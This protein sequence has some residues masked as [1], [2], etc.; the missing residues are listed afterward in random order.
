MRNTRRLRYLIP[1]F[2]V[3]LATPPMA[4]Q[5]AP[6]EGIRQN[7]PKVHAIV[8][9]RI[10]PRPGRVIESGTVIVRD[11]LIVDV[12]E[13]VSPPPDCRLWDGAGL[14]VYPGLIEPYAHIGLETDKDADTP[15]WNPHV[16]SHFAAAT[17]YAPEKKELE[18]LRALG[19]TAA[20]VVPEAGLFRG[21]SA[22]VTLADGP[23]L[24]TV[25]RPGVAQ[26]LALRK[27]SGGPRSPG[28]LTYPT[29]LMGTIALARQTFLDA[30]W[31]RD[32]HAAYGRSPRGQQA[33]ELNDA[34]AELVPVVAGEG[35]LA[36]EVGSDLMFLRALRLADEFD[37]QL[38]VRGSGHEYRILDRV[39]ASGVPVILPVDFPAAPAIADPAD[40][41]QFSLVQLQH[42]EAAPVNPAR[43]HEAGIPFAF[44]S[45]GLEKPGQ[46]RANIR[47][48]IE[49]GLHP[50][51]ALAALTTAPAG[52]AGVSHLLGTIERGKR[53]HLVIADGDLFGEKTKILDV[54]IDGQR[55][56]LE[57]RPH[58]DPRGQW[59]LV[60]EVPDTALALDLTIEGELEALKG[61]LVADSLEIPLK[62]V[63]LERHRISLLFPGDSLGLSG[64]L[65]LRGSVRDTTLFGRGRTPQGATL[66]WHAALAGALPA[67]TTS[68][69]EPDP[70]DRPPDPVFP[71]G[72][73][74]L[75]ESPPQP[76]HLLVTG[77]TIW[78]SGPA[79]VIEG[80]DLLVRRGKIAAVG[81][82]IEAPDGVVV[83]D[84][85]GMHI[86]PGLI[87]AHAH[88][89]SAG[90]VNESSQAASA[91]VRIVDVLDSYSIHIYRQLAG[92][93][94]ASH[95]LHG[96]ANPIGGQCAAIKLRWGVAPQELLLEG[97]APTIKFALG[98]NVKQSNWGDD[99]TK[100]Y[101][102]SRMGV[103]QIIRDRFAAALDY[104]REWED[105]RQRGKKRGS[106]PPRLDLEL[107]ALL[108]VLSGERLVHCHAYRQDEILMFMRVA[109][110][111]G[112]TVGTFVHALEGYKVAEILREHG[113]EATTFSD[114]WAY[115]FEVYDAIPYN[116][117]LLHQVGVGVSL[118]SDSQ[119]VGRRLNTEAAK[120]V[121]YGG[122]GE[123]EALH[124]VTIAAARQLG[125]QAVVGS[126]EPGKDADFVIWNGPPLSSY[127][128]CEQT[129]VDGRRY[130]ERATDLAMR[131]QVE[132]ERTRLTQKI[133]SSDQKEDD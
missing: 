133:L 98:E 89:A 48:A 40:A 57:P 28:V 39:K 83:V 68:A 56:E 17:S 129:W 100:R 94:T 20:L 93:T 7:T 117:A 66:R 55:Y 123:E 131:Q 35:P 24:E 2:L 10:V 46:I 116:A 72:A 85:A 67:D 45:D 5:T 13:S 29:S 127:T 19:Y 36:I 84:A 121:R 115:K 79:G 96:S 49:H 54:W 4:D 27:A 128:R 25:V 105:Y 44:T 38:I 61:K 51:Q 64:F 111:F 110:D 104:E 33:P 118:N 26:H 124:F 3:L 30:R 9:A 81:Q 113:A 77:A 42:W 112:F 125:A 50:D 60:V 59:R 18:A 92:G 99:F 114:W 11:G 65:Q 74:G 132:A 88:I 109:A 119:E 108:E 130:F 82:G 58:V 22:L 70:P 90:G 53:A 80:G 86:T 6:V 91:E 107:E 8:G 97:A 32:A 62:Q 101:P 43:L 71:P 87:D 16:R 52:I 1:A 47:R 15:H 120:A 12:G 34:L 69:D 73:F 37:L 41:L 14:T 21:R 126:L 23:A 63:R 75:S 95:I 31:Y 76:E 103:E 78:T 106:I 102:Q 122:V